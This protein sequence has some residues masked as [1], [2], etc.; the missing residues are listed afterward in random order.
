[1][2]TSAHLLTYCPN[3]LKEGR[4]TCSCNWSAPIRPWFTS[5]TDNVSKRLAAMRHTFWPF[6]IHVTRTQVGVTCFEADVAGLLIL[7][8]I[9]LGQMDISDSD[10]R[11]RWVGHLGIWAQTSF[12]NL[13][14]TRE[15]A[16]LVKMWVLLS[17]QNGHLFAIWWWLFHLAFLVGN[18]LRRKG[19]C[20]GGS[21]HSWT[22]GYDTVSIALIP[23]VYLSQPTL[24]LL[25]STTWLRLS[26]EMWY[27]PFMMYFKGH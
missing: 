7:Y 23:Q 25:S 19:E 18:S 26:A 2:L 13:Y 21:E 4:P 15:K 5:G 20:R 1:M 14:F 9:F 24:L 27:M 6:C 8:S 22:S 11:K 3:I 10:W 16:V 12:S 17:K